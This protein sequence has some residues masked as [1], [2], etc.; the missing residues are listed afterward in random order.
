M[1]PAY[2]LGVEKRLIELEVPAG[3]Q[4]ETLHDESVYDDVR[5]EDIENNNQ[6][7]ETSF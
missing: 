5:E 2:G 4:P 6:N 7:E 1:S 3:E